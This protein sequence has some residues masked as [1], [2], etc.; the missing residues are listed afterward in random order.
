MAKAPH[1]I[2]PAF[3]AARQ[4]LAHRICSVTCLGWCCK[5]L[6]KRQAQWAAQPRPL[7]SLWI[8]D[9]LTLTQTR[10]MK[11]SPVSNP[12]NLEMKL[13]SLGYSLE[14]PAITPVPW[15]HPHASIPPAWYDHKAE[16]LWEK[17]K[18]GALHIAKLL[19]PKALWCVLSHCFMN[20]L[21]WSESTHSLG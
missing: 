15:K 19:P 3:R 4:P 12:S 1:W 5:H 6:G 7:D 16:G 11:A 9:V 13:D 21:L 20:L 2:W 17:E 8:T 14:I 10:R 18:Q